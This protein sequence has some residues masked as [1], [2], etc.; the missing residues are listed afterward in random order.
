MRKEGLP[1]RETAPHSPPPHPARHRPAG[2][3]ETPPHPPAHPPRPAAPPPTR[4]TSPPRLHGELH[5]RRDADARVVVV[6]QC[7]HE[8]VLSGREVAVGDEGLERR[9]VG[10][11]HAELLSEE[12]VVP[13]VLGPVVPAAVHR[14]VEVALAEPWRLT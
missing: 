1:Q 7:D 9:R 10:A 4:A 3:P 13:R 2:G 12:P 11:A 8:L 6:G 5:L 14:E